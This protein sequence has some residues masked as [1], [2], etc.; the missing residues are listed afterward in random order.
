MTA[1]DPR[2]SF[3]YFEHD[4]RPRPNCAP[5]AMS[6]PAAWRDRYRV[7][8]PD[9]KVDFTQPTLGWISRRIGCDECPLLARNAD[10]GNANSGPVFFEPAANEQADLTRAPS[11]SEP[12]HATDSVQKSGPVASKV[13]ICLNN[14]K[15]VV[16]AAVSE[17]TQ[18]AGSRLEGRDGRGGVLDQFWRPGC[19]RADEK[20]WA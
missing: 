6:H 12:W 19:C 13:C 2:R 11:R 8:A 14:A 9:I 20:L 3:R 18:R 15:P 5:P 4:I 7:P 17:K 1:N 16:G 10:V